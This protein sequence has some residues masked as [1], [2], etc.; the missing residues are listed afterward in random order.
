MV[1]EQ[2]ASVR[3]SYAADQPLSVAHPVSRSERSTLD[4]RMIGGIQSRLPQANGKITAPVSS[5]SGSEQERP[6]LVCGAMLEQRLSPAEYCERESV[7]TRQTAPTAA[8]TPIDWRDLSE[9]RK[10]D[11]ATLR[12][13]APAPLAAVLHPA[14]GE[15][16]G[17]SQSPGSSVSI[18]IL[19]IGHEQSWP[20]FWTYPPLP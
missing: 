13:T 9:A 14:Q 17:Y 5:H 3:Y 10:D 6:P 16:C 8:R 2:R 19:S 15:R 12:H 4:G 1:H 18:S 20:E 11:R 7:S